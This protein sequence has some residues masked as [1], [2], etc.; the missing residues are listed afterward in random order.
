MKNILLLTIMLLGFL[1][2]NSKIKNPET[3]PKDIAMK[4]VINKNYA[5]DSTTLKTLQMEIVNII[6]EKTCDDVSQWKISAMGSKA[7][8]G[9]AYYIAYPKESEERLLPK[10]K[11]YSAQQSSFN[12]KYGI[13]SDCIIENEPK[14]I[15]CENGKAVLQYSSLDEISN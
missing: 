8:G 13:M 5:E 14:G 9:P 3:L 15:T 12:E 6:E 4:K 11:T 7:C 1:S 10:I 2:C